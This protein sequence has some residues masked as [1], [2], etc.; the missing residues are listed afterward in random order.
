MPPVPYTYQKP[1]DDRLIQ[2]LFY[3]HTWPEVGS[4]IVYKSQITFNKLKMPFFEIQFF[5]MSIVLRLLKY[6]PLHFTKE[7]L[8]FPG[9]I[10]LLPR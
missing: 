3:S 4:K 1:D 5:L 9:D 7:P 8:H 6:F 2:L 10:T